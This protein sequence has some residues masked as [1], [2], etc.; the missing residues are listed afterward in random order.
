MCNSCHSVASGDVSRCQTPAGSQKD[1]A[2]KNQGDYSYYNFINNHK[3]F[4]FKMSV[5]FLYVCII[6]H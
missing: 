5:R 4:V 1:T 2:D 3:K 6:A